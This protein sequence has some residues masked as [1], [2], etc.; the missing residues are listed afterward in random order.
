MAGSAPFYDNVQW[1]AADGIRVP[2]E[3]IGVANIDPTLALV[4][5]VTHDYAAAHADW[6]LAPHETAAS[7]LVV[8]NSNSASNAILPAANPGKPYIVF[9]NTTSGVTFKVT[10]QTGVSVG[11]GKRAILVCESTDIARVTADT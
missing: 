1:P 9:N 10:G 8:K 2:T 3:V 5:S 11:S 4:Y 7:E 6:T